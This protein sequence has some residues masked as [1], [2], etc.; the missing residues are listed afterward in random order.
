MIELQQPPPGENRIPW[1]QWFFKLWTYT[2]YHQL[3]T[4]SDT[5]R[6]AP[7]NVGRLIFNTDDGLINVDDGTQWTDS[8]GTPT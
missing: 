6:P 2:T 4:F 1:S 8:V 3:P 7:G 5:T